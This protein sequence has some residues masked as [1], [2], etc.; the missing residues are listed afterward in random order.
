[1]GSAVHVAIRPENVRL[2]VRDTADQVPGQVLEVS[3]QG[4]QTVYQLAALD[5]RIEA[6]EMGTEPRFAP[7]ETVP[8]TLPGVHCLAYAA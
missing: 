3:Y 1:M 5:A 4:V 7:G 6:V 2:G 8:I